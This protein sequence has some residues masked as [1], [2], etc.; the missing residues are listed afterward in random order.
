MLQFGLISYR[1][2]PDYEESMEFISK[3]LDPSAINDV[4]LNFIKFGIKKN[5]KI[6]KALLV[7]VRLYYWKY[8]NHDELRA[9]LDERLDLVNFTNADLWEKQEIFHCLGSDFLNTFF[10][11]EHPWRILESYGTTQ[12]YNFNSIDADWQ[13]DWCYSPP[14]TGFFSVIENIIIAKFFFSLHKRKFRISPPE[15]WWRYPIDFYSI[16]EKFCP[17]DPSGLDDIRYISWKDIRDNF[18]YLHPSYYEILKKY[19]VDQ[20]SEVKS[21]IKI[22]ISNR[23]KEYSFNFP[24]HVNSCIYFVRGG[25]KTV[26]ETIDMPSELLMLDLVEA[27]EKY[28]KIAILSDD[29]IIAQDIVNKFGNSS[30]YNI[31]D[32]N[33]NGYYINKLHS[34]ADVF[35]ILNN[36]LLLSE[37]IMSLSCP[38]SNLVNSAHWSNE[39]AVHSMPL[40]SVPV[41]RLLYL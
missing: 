30:I 15:N 21:L 14:P 29:Y 12:D 39:S 36:Y 6:G 13:N 35:A 8:I 28:K 22:F 19:K 25:D 41:R 10:T 23:A 5:P 24:D 32:K 37:T 7:A 2:D 40:H 3:F 16:F 1:D 17:N 4:H 27:Q 33:K 38:S 9:L 18:R 20:Y 34:S 26:L 11:W 31:T